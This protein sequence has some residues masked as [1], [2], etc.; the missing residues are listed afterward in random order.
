MSSASVSSGPPRP[1]AD[2]SRNVSALIEG[3]GGI[4]RLMN[5]H[6]R[7]R[8]EAEH[9]HD[10]EAFELQGLISEEDENEDENKDRS[11]KARDEENRP[12]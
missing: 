7:S 12:S 2:H 8:S 5:G 11:G 1:R 9:I 6:L 3:N 4:T 10:A